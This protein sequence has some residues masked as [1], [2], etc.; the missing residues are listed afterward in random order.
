MYDLIII[1]GGP[2]G[3]SAALSAKRHSLKYLVIEKG[4][5]ANTVFEYPIARR[6]FS[7]PGEVELEPQ[8]LPHDRKP[9]REE[10][11]SHY[12]EIATREQLCIHTFEQ[13]EQIGPI[14]GGFLV[15]TNKDSYSART[16]LVAVGGFG[17]QRKLDVPGESTSRVSYHFSEAHPFA[18]K[19]VLVIGGGNSAAEAAIYL[20]ESGARVTLS[21]RRASLDADVE[22][23]SIG[24]S[25]NRA[26]AKIK[27]WVREPLDR[28]ASEGKLNVI[29]SSEILDILPDSAILKLRGDAR[30]LLEEIIEVPCEHIFALIGADPDTLLLEQPG[31]EIAS[32]GRP[33]YD[34]ITHETTVPGIYVAGHLTRELHMKKA[35]EV[36][37]QV[38]DYIASSVSDFSNRVLLAT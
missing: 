33:V 26:S 27:P 18:F 10:T 38:V 21:L 25:N 11:L 15:K 24:A 6:L 23:D 8:A 1:G 31:A 34:P 12:I 7:S 30:Y 2:A 37:R 13:V 16:L 36:G 4:V 32:D 14:E 28:A 9:T 3:L 35:I 22:N 20:V 19:N 29:T 5:I 17:R